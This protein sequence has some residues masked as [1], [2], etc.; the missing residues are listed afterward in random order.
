MQFSFLA[1]V[2]MVCLPHSGPIENWP[3][4]EVSFSSLCRVPG[5]YLPCSKGRSQLSDFLRFMY[6][7]IVFLLG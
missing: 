6:L 5:L 4:P 1:S 3:T 2:A 7:F